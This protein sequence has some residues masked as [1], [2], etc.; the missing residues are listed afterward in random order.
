M[1]SGTSAQGIISHFNVWS[2]KAHTEPF[3]W[4]NI[5]SSYLV[6]ANERLYFCFFHNVYYSAGKHT[7]LITGFIF[8]FHV[9]N[10]SGNTRKD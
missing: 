1:M 3:T 7:Y 4:Q 9:V 5:Q 8:M 2:N 10:K 6:K